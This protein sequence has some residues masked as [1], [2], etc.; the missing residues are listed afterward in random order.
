[1]SPV[2]DATFQTESVKCLAT[3]VKC[4]GTWMD[5]QLKI[6]DFSPRNSDFDHSLENSSATNGE[7]GAN[8]DYDVHTDTNS[9]LSDAATLEQRRV[10]KIEFQVIYFIKFNSFL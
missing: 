8:M 4:M 6:R 3:L 5:Q 7:E 2:Q 1:M 9:G 10:Y